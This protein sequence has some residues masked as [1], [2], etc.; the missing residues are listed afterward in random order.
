[1][2]EILQNITSP[3]ILSQ[4]VR[5]HID[6]WVKKYPPDQKQSAVLSALTLVQ[7]E[8][9]GYLTQELMDAVAAYLGM[10][11]I[12]VY[13]AATF[14]SMF[15]LKPV[16]KHKICVCT[17][18]SC[19]LCGSDEIV[20]HLKE[21]LGITFGETTKDGKFS[22]KSVECLAACCGAPMMQIGHDYYENLSC[23]KVDE[24]LASLE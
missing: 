23:Q 1:M 13:E 19:M 15:E 5:Q 16:G 6:N 21:K 7:T 24:I 14:Y 10:P 12:A 17:N 22:L 11:K 9:G 4:R 18:I 20:A 3:E 8:N 2:T